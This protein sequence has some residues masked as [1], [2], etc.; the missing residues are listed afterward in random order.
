M[1][2]E[3]ARPLVSMASLSGSRRSRGLTDIIPHYSSSKVSGMSKYSVS[4]IRRY[5]FRISARDFKKALQDF[6][7]LLLRHILKKKEVPVL[8]D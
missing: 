4:A 6:E 2:M 1:F 3:S 7:E 5:L 8:V